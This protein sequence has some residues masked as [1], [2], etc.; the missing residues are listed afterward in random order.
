MIRLRDRRELR[1][2]RDALAAR[3]RLGFVPTMGGLHAG[4][5]SLVRR[6]RAECDLLLASVFVNPLQFNDAEDLASYPREED[7]DC[8]RLAA[9][10]ADAAYLP[11][12]ADLYDGDGGTR[13]Q[14]GPAGETFEGAC[15]PGH[16]AGVLTVVLKLFQRVRPQRAYFGEKDAQQLFLVRRMVADLDLPVEVVACPTVR[17]PDGLALSSRNARL[18]P[19]ERAA[20]TVLYRALCAARERFAAGERDPAELGAAMARVY[21]AAGVAPDY[22]AV[23]DEDSFAPAAVGRPGAWRAV[24]AARVGRTRLIDNLLLGPC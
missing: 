23:V 16:F 8:A 5:D 12:V 17:E 3:A 21:A 11:E 6:A 14:P 7:A 13:V 24:T 18:R 19:E 2:W 1:R 20:A 10:G 22:A 15:R 4:H 9:A